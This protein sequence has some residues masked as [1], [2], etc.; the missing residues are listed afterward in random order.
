MLYQQVTFYYQPEP[1]AIETVSGTKPLD[2]ND[3]EH[4]L[5]HCLAAQY[6]GMKYVY[7]ENGSGAS[8]PIDCKLVS[9]LSTKL[10]LPLIV[11]EVLRQKSCK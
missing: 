7:L 5:Y 3:F 10:N 1:T 6:F 2:S 11:G 8:N 9:F 4:I